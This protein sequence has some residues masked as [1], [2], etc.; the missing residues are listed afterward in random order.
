MDRNIRKNKFKDYTLRFNYKIFVKR[1][2]L[3]FVL[4]FFTLLILFNPFVTHCKSADLRLNSQTTGVLLNEIR[5][6]FIKSSIKVFLDVPFGYYNYDLI[7]TNFDKKGT[8]V[9]E[10][11]WVTFNLDNVRYDLNFGD[12]LRIRDLS[13]SEE[14]NVSFS[15]FNIGKV[16][17]D[18]MKITND[19]DHITIESPNVKDINWVYEICISKSKSETINKFLLILLIIALLL[20]SLKSL[21]RFWFGC[22]EY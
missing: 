14:H 17:G 1:I 8:L 3:L 15:N 5:D 4:S 21:F 19:V 12:T 22:M 6:E 11:M 13:F 9:N 16:K 2:F 10:D 7:L 18:Y 20:P